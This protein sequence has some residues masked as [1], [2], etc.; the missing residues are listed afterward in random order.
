MELVKTPGLSLS[1]LLY[2]FVITAF[3]INPYKG[4][5]F[6]TS[7]EV[8]D[9]NSE[10]VFSSLSRNFEQTIKDINSGDEQTS[11]SSSS[12][13]PNSGDEKGSSDDDPNTATES[14]NAI[15]SNSTTTN[16]LQI[17]NQTDLN[18]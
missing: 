18:K 9:Q 7:I 17:S 6:A 13:S 14:S 5:S 4:D 11:S 1:V 15:N 3:S 12:E 2:F 8:T 10:G 16:D